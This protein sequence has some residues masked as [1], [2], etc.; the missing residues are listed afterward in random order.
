[1]RISDPPSTGPRPYRESRGAL[2]AGNSMGG[3]ACA[4]RPCRRFGESDRHVAGCPIPANRICPPQTPST[5]RRPSWSHGFPIRRRASATCVPSIVSNR[6][7]GAASVFLAKRGGKR[8]FM[9][10]ATQIA[11]VHHPR[12]ETE[13]QLQC[14]ALLKLAIPPEAGFVFHVPNQGKRSKIGGAIHKGMGMIPG[15][16]DLA[17]IAYQHLDRATTGVVAAMGVIELKRP[18]APDPRKLLTEDQIAFRDMCNLRGIPYL[19]ANDA[20]HVMSWAAGFYH[21]F[22]HSFRVVAV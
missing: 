10:Q 20:R 11:G 15:F 14:V 12:T 13:L 17:L 22:G 1:M 18:G 6:P 2:G 19:C 4:C 7:K 5:R 3:E 9:A 8:A 21:D 16:P